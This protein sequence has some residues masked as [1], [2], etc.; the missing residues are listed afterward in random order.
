MGWR[1]T[2]RQVASGELSFKPEAPSDFQQGIGMLLKTGANYIQDQEDRRREEA[3]KF[4]EEQKAKNEE[5]NK[6][7]KEKNAL[8]NTELS[9]LPTKAS[10]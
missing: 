9:Q 7:R 3:M 5:F 8:D 1:D 4:A 10:L 2:Q 6:N